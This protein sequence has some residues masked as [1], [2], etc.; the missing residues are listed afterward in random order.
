MV[1]LA[2]PVFQSGEVAVLIVTTTHGKERI[3]EQHLPSS[4]QVLAVQSNDGSLSARN[5]LEAVS[6]SVTV[7]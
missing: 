2:L 1:D 6:R 4:V 3:Y 5:I 7:R